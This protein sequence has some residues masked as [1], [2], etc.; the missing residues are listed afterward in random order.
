MT[1][2]MDSQRPFANSSNALKNFTI[3]LASRGASEAQAIPFHCFLGESDASHSPIVK[4]E[5]R[6]SVNM[7]LIFMSNTSERKAHADATGSGENGN[8]SFYLHILMAF[9]CGRTLQEMQITLK[10]S[11]AA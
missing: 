5:I 1:T 2:V 8:F 6:G 10:P 4:T 3:V 7:K 11:S 9:L